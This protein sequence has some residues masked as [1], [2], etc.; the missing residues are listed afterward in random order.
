MSNPRALAPAPATFK[1]HGVPAMPPEPYRYL[2]V[3]VR[4][5]AGEASFRWQVHERD[6]RLTEGS[7]WTY[8]TEREA[9][10]EGNAAARAIRKRAAG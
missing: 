3:R 5:S 8:T 2:D 4:R 10:R 1:Q 6:G 9:L 7:A